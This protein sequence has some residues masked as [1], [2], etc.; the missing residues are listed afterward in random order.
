MA[1]PHAQLRKQLSAPGLLQT[2]RTHFSHIA[3]PRRKGVTLPLVDTLMSGLAVFGLKY[4]S[5]LKFDEGRADAVLQ[6]NLKTLYGV[7]QAPCD[8]QLRAILDRVDP[9]A[10]QPVFR[11]LH[12]QVQRHKGWDGYRFL[13][14]HYLVSLDGTGHFASNAV[15]CPEC[16]VK[17]RK[18]GDEYYHQLVAAVM[19]HPER[20]TVLPMGIEA[21]TR[22]D[23]TTKN[24][25]ERNA[26]QRLLTR[27]R[28]DFPQTP[29]IILE[30]SLASNG[31]H[32]KRLQELDLRFI[33]GVKEGDHQ[34]LFEHIDQHLQANTCQEWSYEDDQGTE[35]GYRFIADLPLNASHSDVRVNYLEHWIIQKGKTTL[36]SWVT[37]LE[38]TQD[39]VQPIAKGGRARWK[40]ENETFNTLKNQG[41]ELEHNYG[42]GQQHLAT[43]FGLLMMLAFLIDQI[44]ELSCR[45]FQAARAHYR[46]RTTLWERLRALFVNFYIPD[47]QTVWKTLAKGGVGAALAPDTS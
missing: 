2:V 42:H 14:D 41:Y 45:L 3:E 37:D 16:C 22:Q 31:P 11:L 19:V 35:Y 9:L 44:Q 18:T 6:H 1:A 26:S 20:K 23:G 10:L 8:T 12:R 13:G 21:I 40:V 47:W 46:S 34:H 33:I 4:P 7:A 15:S 28:D 38:L 32:I 43:V 30:D 29:M 25:G 17:H 36:F 5:L 39:T 27:L 24:D